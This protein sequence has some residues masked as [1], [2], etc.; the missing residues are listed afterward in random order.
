MELFNQ[1]MMRG[2]EQDNP[3]ELHCWV[4]F[5]WAP[6]GSA[7]FY[8]EL[9]LFDHYHENSVGDATTETGIN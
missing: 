3:E 6:S 9:H 7:L 8:K 5:Q 4:W 1:G 2:L